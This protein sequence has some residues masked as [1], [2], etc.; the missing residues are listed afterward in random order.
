MLTQFAGILFFW[1]VS[2]K[3]FVKALLKIWKIESLGSDSPRV[4]AVPKLDFPPVVSNT[5][6][7]SH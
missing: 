4:T 7:P 3:F 6:I 2:S 5:R 1:K